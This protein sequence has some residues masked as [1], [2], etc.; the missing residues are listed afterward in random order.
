MFVHSSKIVTLDGVKDA[1]M[2]IEGG[3]IIE[4]LNPSE[5]ETIDLELGNNIVLP[6]IID[7]HNHGTMGYGLGAPCEDMEKEAEYRLL[8]NTP[9]SLFFLLQV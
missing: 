5:V 7:T 9:L 4:F 6:G 2:K 3:K 1:V 8:D